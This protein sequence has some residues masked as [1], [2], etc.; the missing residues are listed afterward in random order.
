MEQ[1]KE[2]KLGEI[3]SIKYGKDHKGLGDGVIPVF[4]S[5]GIMRYVNSHI[6]TGPSILIPR[7]GTLNNILFSDAPFWTVDTMF[8]SIINTELVNPLFLYYAIY[9]K[10][11]ESLNVGTAV[12]SLTVPVI[13]S[14]TV[15]LPH[16]K[17]QNRIVEVLKS[18][19]DKIELNRRKNDN[20]TRFAA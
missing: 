10:D 9:K 15:K 14:I 2:Y 19:D 6:Y 7:K 1:W 12:P 5:G 17:L 18:L 16:L 11:F 8:W 20:L 13:E 3:I 4:G